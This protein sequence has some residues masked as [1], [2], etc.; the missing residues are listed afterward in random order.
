VPQ[1]S[2]VV[3]IIHTEGGPA[4]VVGRYGRGPGGTG[5]LES[6]PMPVA[7]A[8]EAARV[9][10]TANAGRA[11]SSMGGDGTVFVHFNSDEQW[12]AEWGEWSWLRRFGAPVTR[13]SRRP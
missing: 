6:E 13:Q 1:G 7:P 12:D 9:E 11:K 10:A 2:P 5:W 4:A 8:L 3:S